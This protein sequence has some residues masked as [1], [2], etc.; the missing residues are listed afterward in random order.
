MGLN[1]WTAAGRCTKPPE[2]KHVGQQG[3]PI[4]VFSI[5][6]DSRQKI[7]GEWQDTPIFAKVELW[8]NRAETIHEWFTKGSPVAFTGELRE[9]TWTDR[10]GKERKSLAVKAS[11]VEPLETKRQRE[12]RAAGSSSGKSGD[13][14]DLDAG[15]KSDPDEDIPF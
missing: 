13:D 2:L 4:L 15:S 11:N 6:I 5:A 1:S 10:E 14:W 12:E 7:D 9:E 8:G 3:I